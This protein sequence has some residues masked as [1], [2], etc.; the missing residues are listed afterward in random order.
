ML[1]QTIALLCS[2]GAA[3][4]GRAPGS[5]GG[6]GH[7]VITRDNGRTLQ[8]H[9]IEDVAAFIEFASLSGEG[10]EDK[11]LDEGLIVDDIPEMDEEL[12]TEIGVTKTMHRKRF[13][14]FAKQ[15]RVAADPPEDQPAPPPPPK[16]QQQKKKKKP[17]PPPPPQPQPAA[18]P[19]PSPATKS[20][21]AHERWKHA[22]A[23]RKAELKADAKKRKEE[24]KKAGKLQKGVDAD[25][26]AAVEDEDLDAVVEALDAGANVDK[27]FDVSG[28]GQTPM[29]YASLSGYTEI[30]S[31]L[32]DRGADL[33]IGMES[34][35][36]TPIH[37]AAFQGQPDVVKLLLDHGEDALHRH[38]DGFIPMHRACWGNTP[39]HTEAVLAFLEHGV[40]VLT[41][42]L[43]PEFGNGPSRFE[44][45]D[46]MMTPLNM[47]GSEPHANCA[48][49]SCLSRLVA[50]GAF[51]TVSVCCSKPHDH[52]SA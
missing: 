19:P 22:D 16:Q 15:L 40:D 23:K 3:A 49:L 18:Q 25:L 39:R 29:M 45:Q 52:W 10:Y 2:A 38:K 7:Y 11:L 46:G 36:F 12:L 28:E 1:L 4:A 37:G 14:R 41:T 33:S 47:S 9:P 43:D 26:A 20:E 35:A 32:L 30:A 48:R 50:Q 6:M 8:D 31:V 27:Y 17:P 44:S 21:E 13:L 34:T 42:A 51:L 24:K 5:G